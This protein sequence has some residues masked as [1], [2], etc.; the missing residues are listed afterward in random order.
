MT[1]EDKTTPM[2]RQAEPA[3]APN[4][5]IVAHRGASKQAP[6]NTIP[7]FK[8]AWEQGADAIEGDFYLT[9]DGAIVCIHDK[10]TKRVSGVKK[11]VEDT[12][13]EELRKLDAGSWFG[14]KW[15]GT[16]IPL[17]SE[18]FATI[19]DGKKIYI[20]I[21]SGPEILPGLFEEVAKSGLKKNQ[22]IVISFNKDVI[23]NLKSKDQGIKAFWLSDFK[24]DKF[25]GRTKPSFNSVIDVLRQTGADGFSSTHKLI[26]DS[27]IKTIQREGFEYHVW[28][29]DDPETAQRFKR[30]GAKSITTNL[31]GYM[32]KSL[33]GEER[34]KR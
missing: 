31:P 8:L 18:V 32:K 23:R 26:D 4:L 9:K 33:E 21:K 22:V 15:Q 5:M 3:N 19:P 13:L 6:E 1:V 29:V 12:T 25:S 24:R 16:Q 11:V 27:F 20:E 2:T 28:T 34:G 17:I 10:D 7:A 14:K 30:L